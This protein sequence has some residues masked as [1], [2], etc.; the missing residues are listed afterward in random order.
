MKMRPSLRVALAQVLALCLSG[1]ACFSAQ[2]DPLEQ[3]RKTFAAKVYAANQTDVHEGR[4]QAL[5]RAIV[6]L[7]VR[8]DDDFRWKVEVVREKEN[9]PEMTAKALQSVRNVPVPED[10][11]DEDAYELTHVG[12]LE[13]WL[14][15]SNGRFTLK[16]LAKPQLGAASGRT[17]D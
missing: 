13:A 1:V 2:A 4:P 11:S 15:E 8:I 9:Q 3:F 12:F 16:T 14:F 17:N 6:V 7:R 10:I 5:L